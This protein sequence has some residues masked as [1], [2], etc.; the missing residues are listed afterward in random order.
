MSTARRNVLLITADQ[1]RGDTL[2]A[3]GHVCIQT[4]HLDALARESVIFRSHFANTSPCGPSRASLHTGLYA[5]NHRSVLNGTPLAA[6]HTT[7]A[8]EARRAGYSPTLFGYTDTSI[9]PAGLDPADP[10]LSSCEGVLPGYDAALH[11]KEDAKPW[12]GW[13]ARR[14]GGA[15]PLLADVIRPQGGKLG[16]DA[17]Y[18]P[19]ES[20]TGFVTDAALAWLATRTQESWFVHVSHLW[21][22]PP[23]AVPEAWTRRYPLD[24]IPP[25]RRAAHVDE[26]A[27]VHPLQ[28]ALMATTRTE[29]FVPGID[30]FAKDLTIDRI[31]AMRR[32]YYA[33]MSEVDHHIG[34][35]IAFLRE[36][37]QLERTLVIFTS[38]HGE[39]LGDHHLLG[40][41]GFQDE[42]FHIPL[43]IRDP[44][45]G[46][47][48]GDAVD[49]ITEAVDLMPTVLEFL[50]CTI[51]PELDGESLSD[52]LAGTQPASWRDAAYWSFDYR[53]L[54]DDPAS[55]H[56]PH[57]D[58]ANLIARRDRDSLYVHCGDLPAMYFD[59]HTDPLRRRNRA[60]DPA[61][62]A[63]R[64]AAADAMLTW[65]LRHE[66]RRLSNV[67]LTPDGLRHW[68]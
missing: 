55:P 18:A 22:H 36:T 66:A 43:I 3:L 44:R 28:A 39:C 46:A 35:L 37:M 41:R 50:N 25:P 29:S 52:F 57:P 30:G 7:M 34:L 15:A 42:A 54:A 47:V 27:A 24:A 32:Q 11:L 68:R 20:L 26:D 40:K 2:G 59:L 5:H 67:V 21:P 6:Q 53:G 4:P 63:S 31:R 60:G 65:R 16:G 58:H 38:D 51:P 33:A 14:R 19:E 23:W 45:P 49:A 1:W 12:L 48:R 13:L 56:K 8:L 64:A 17:G 9:D 61:Y 62:A 10:R